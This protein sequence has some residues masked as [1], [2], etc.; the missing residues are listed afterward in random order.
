MKELNYET[1]VV[2]IEMRSQNCEKLLLASSC[3]SIHPSN[4]M[5]Q[6]GSRRTDFHEILYLST[7]RKTVEKI[8][9]PQKSDK[10]N[11]SFT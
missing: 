7:F 10:N 2:V 6:F 3:L 8:Q 11:G 9:V 5:E 1:H 4:H